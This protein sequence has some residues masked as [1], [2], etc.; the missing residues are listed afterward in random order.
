M[1]ALMQGGYSKDWVDM[2]TARK[3]KNTHTPASHGWHCQH[4]SCSRPEQPCP[5]ACVAAAGAIGGRLT[6]SQMY[7]SFTRPS[8]AAAGGV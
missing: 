7:C 3:V 5:I 4:R 8:A 6:R 2:N 1:R